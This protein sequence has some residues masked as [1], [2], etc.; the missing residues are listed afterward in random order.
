MVHGAHGFARAL[1]EVQ[2]LSLGKTF[3]S[4]GVCV[5]HV[6][7]VSALHCKSERRVEIEGDAGKAG[8]VDGEEKVDNFALA[9]G[10]LQYR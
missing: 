4:L 9:T 10:V 3:S 5:Y 6:L 7:K 1:E 2:K 8:L